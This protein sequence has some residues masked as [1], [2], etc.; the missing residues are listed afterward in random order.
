MTPLSVNPSS[1]VVMSWPEIEATFQPLRT[2]A[3]NVLLS[4][5]YAIKVFHSTSPQL[6]NELHV[7]SK[8]NEMTGKTLLFGHAYG[9]ILSPDSP[10]QFGE[11]D[12]ES[13]TIDSA[14]DE[15]L[16]SPRIV[17]GGH[18]V[19]LFMEPIESNFSDLPDE[20][21]VNEDFFFEILI[22]L[23]YA[24]KAFSF[25]HWDIHDG[26]LMFNTLGEEKLR[27]YKIG[28]DNKDHFWG[29]D[30]VFYVSIRSRIQPKLIDFGKSV[31]DETGITTEELMGD[32]WKD[33]KHAKLWNK[34]D[35][36]H[37]ALL[38][39][40]RENLSPEFRHFLEEIVLP[41]YK[42]SMYATK[43][44]KDSSVN[45]AHIEELLRLFYDPQ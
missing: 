1:V 42:S 33:P 4:E 7:M 30:N 45:Y 12:I 38:F 40:H 18:Y 26:Q 15:I 31:V 6:Q 16:S 14:G 8:L 10:W 28:D 9:T 39:S 41:T 24:R 44:E 13:T 35:I 5:D 19:Y 17:G 21:K 2:V 22:G 36:Y 43:L 25:C 20:P 11:D 23:Y 32:V 3:D 34:S 27:C 37:L 29:G